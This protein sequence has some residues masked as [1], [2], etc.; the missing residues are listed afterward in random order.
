MPPVN[1][2]HGSCSKL[3]NT[4]ERSKYL[5]DGFNETYFDT[6]RFQI[7]GRRTILN[8][9]NGKC[10][11]NIQGYKTR[12]KVNNPQRL[13]NPGC[14]ILGNHAKVNDASKYS[15]HIH[16]MSGG[17]EAFSSLSYFRGKSKFESKQKDLRYESVTDY[18]KMGCIQDFVILVGR[19]EKALEVTQ[20]IRMDAIAHDGALVEELRLNETLDYV[21]EW[22]KP[23]A[24]WSEDYMK[25]LEFK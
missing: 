12:Q 13:F 16:H 19:V 21:Y 25:S 3:P 11:I 5:P 22:D 8:T 18:S 14:Y 1:L 17:F 10:L 9:Q 20:S 23:A 24:P 2:E 7:R 15:I 4:H 6:L